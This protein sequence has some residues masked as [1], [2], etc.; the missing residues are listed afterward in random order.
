MAAVRTGLLALLAV[1]VA[2]LA[3]G[4]AHARSGAHPYFDDGG[5]LRWYRSYAAA[6]QA[7]QRE[8]KLIFIESGRPNCGMCATLCRSVIA[9]RNIRGRISQ[10]AVGLVSNCDAMEPVVAR[11][12]RQNL[13]RPTVLPLVGFVTP[14]GRWVTG[15]Y[16]SRSIAQFS[17][18]LDRATQTLR[19]IHAPQSEPRTPPVPVPLSP[20]P[21]SP[22]SPVSPAP[23]PVSPAPGPAQPAP[24]CP[25]VYV[26]PGDRAP[27]LPDP[28]H[29]DCHD[30]ACPGGNCAI[31]PEDPCGGFA[32]P[33][34]PPPAP[35]TPPTPPAPAPLAT[36]PPVATRPPAATRSGG[37]PEGT[38]PDPRVRRVGAP[39]LGSA[40]LGM[41][42]VASGS[43]D[44][45]LQSRPTPQPP[46]ALP[47]RPR[48]GTP[49]RPAGTSVPIAQRKAEEAA[50]RG[51]WG[52]VLQ[53]TA[54]IPELAHHAERAR[55]WARD[56]LETS[57]RL[58]LADR[59][60]PARKGLEAVATEFEGFAAA[61]DA[62]RGLEALVLVEEL[63]YLSKESVVRASVRARAHER[64][65]GS[66]WASLFRDPR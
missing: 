35:A 58:L 9:N 4:D 30:P 60:D 31:D 22:V 6:S 2:G 7:A 20:A 5:A 61:I 64:M 27:A 53:L 66:R 56:T 33:A 62:E 42:Q 57:L 16:G 10:V 19:R 17:A 8:G 46:A 49:I 44:G 45:D 43:P 11:L 59:L 40:D 1:V 39:P 63:R 18:D 65:R 26:P 24:R 51:Q 37:E 47:I 41:P 15:F 28:S 29:D 12:F 38:L 34:V 55:R 54:E 13:Y 3:P 23:A 52:L 25:P 21:V 32:L 14:R 50:A 36:H 48:D